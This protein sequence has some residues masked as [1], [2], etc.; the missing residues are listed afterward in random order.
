MAGHERDHVLAGLDQDRVDVVRV[1]DADRL[2]LVGQLFPNIFDEDQVGL[3]RLAFI[4]VDLLKTDVVT[5]KGAR[6]HGGDVQPNH[7]VRLKVYI[8]FPQLLN[9]EIVR[10]EIGE[11]L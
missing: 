6:F 10:Y 8:P 9:F 5:E 1:D 2:H 3:L 11:L 7:V 4:E